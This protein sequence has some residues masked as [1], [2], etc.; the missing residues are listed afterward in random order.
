MKPNVFL[1]HSKADKAF[2][3]KL[4][5]DLR[6][7]RINVWY[8]EWEIP[9]GESFRR[10]IFEYGIPSSDLFFVYLTGNS[11][12]SYW[13][14]RELDA[15]FIRDA[16]S[17]GGSLAVFVDSDDIRKEL[18]LDLRSLHSPVL[19]EENYNRPLYQLISRVWEAALKKRVRAAQDAQQLEILRLEK[20][21]AELQAQIIR[22]E[23]SGGTD[24]NG[25]EANLHEI[26]YAINEKDITLAELFLA[27]SSALASGATHRMIE[28]R[29]RELTEVSENTYLFYKDM[30][31]YISDFT[32]PLVISRLVRVQPPTGEWDE[33]FYL[34]EL[35]ISLASKMHGSINP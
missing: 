13:V 33:L 9:V 29:I 5:N 27:L 26:H 12:K 6:T 28:H 15:A 31:Y 14:A 32:G 20:E 3:E 35:G 7:S 1:S 22:L 8:D 16:E 25:L 18:P 30:G 2:I 21:K 11:A 34:T 10:Q 4:A 19:N 17:K 23:T 24:L